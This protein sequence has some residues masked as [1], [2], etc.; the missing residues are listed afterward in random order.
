VVAAVATADVLG[1][2]TWIW[3]TSLLPYRYSVMDLGYAD[4]GGAPP[5]PMAAM[6]H[7]HDATPVGSVTSFIAEPI[8]PADVCRH[9]DRRQPRTLPWLA[10]CKWCH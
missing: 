4:Y 8:R 3:Q 6:L 2:L 9:A 1:P 7:S 5:D 10:Q